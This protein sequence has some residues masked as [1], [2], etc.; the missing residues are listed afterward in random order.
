MFVGMGANSGGGYNL[1]SSLRFRSSASAYLTR[2][3]ASAG[4]RKTF[5][6]SMWA[7]RGKLGTAQYLFSAYNANN[8]N[9]LFQLL[10][11]SSDS[12]YWGVWTS[13][14]TS[15][16]KFRDP[17]A[18]YHIVVKIDTTLVGSSQ[19]RTYVNNVDVTEPSFAGITQNTDLAINNTITHYIGRNGASAADYQDGY[20]TEFNFIDGQALTPSDFGEYDITTGV[21][22]PKEY[23]GT[24]GTN[25]FYLPMKETQQATGFNTV[26]YNGNG[27][28]LKV[29]GVGFNPDLVWVKRRD[30]AVSYHRLI[31]S[32]RGGDKRLAS[33]DTGAETTASTLIQSFDADGYT[34]GTDTGMNASGDR[35]VAWC[36]D[37]GSSTV[38]NTDGTITS[39]VRANPATGFSVVTYVGN[40]TAGATVGHGL[41]TAP[42]MI[43]TKNRDTSTNWWVYHESIGNTKY[44]E[45]N[46]TITGTTNTGAWNNTSPDSNVFTLGSTSPSNANQVVAYCFSEVAGYSKFGSYTGNGSTSGPTVTT[47]FRPAFVMFKCTDVAGKYWN[48]Y[49]NTRDVANPIN[50]ALYPNTSLADTTAGDVD[51]TDTGFQLK[52]TGT[53]FNQSGA[54]YIYMAFADTRDAQFNFDASGNKN[55]WTANNINSNASSET[56]YDIMN[57]VATLTNEDTANFA[58]WNPLDFSGLSAGTIIYTNASFS[59]GNLKATCTTTNS[60]LTVFSTI[61]DSAIDKTYWE[62]TF[63]GQT[64]AYANYVYIG[65]G[66]AGGGAFYSSDGNYYNGSTWS[67]YGATYT[68]N[69]T[70]GIA[71]SLSGNTI[72]FFKNNVSQGVKTISKTGVRPQARIWNDTAPAHIEVNFGQRPFKYTPP[73]GYKKLN[74]YNLPDSTIV[75]GSQYMNPVLYTGNGG[76]NAI[77]TG[78]SPDLV[79]LKNRGSAQDNTLFDSIR[80]TEYYL[81]TNWSG[82][83]STDGNSNHIAY[84]SNGFTL[85]GTNARTNASSNSYVAWNWRGSDSSAVSNTDGTITSTVSANTTSG[86]SIVTYTG[87]GAVGTIGHGLQAA[88]SMIITKRRNAVDGWFT[89]H[90]SLGSDQ[91]MNLSTTAAVGTTLPDYWGTA[92]P[93]SSVYG[94]NTY[95]GNNT[96]GGTFVAYCFAEVEGFS[97]FGSYTGNGSADGPFVYTGFRPAFILGKNSN[98]TDGWFIYDTQRDTYNYVRNF[99]GPHNS[100]AETDYSGSSILFDIVSNGFKVRGSQP[101]IN[102]NGNTIIYMAFAEN[103]FKHSLAR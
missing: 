32:V 69:D 47:G 14:S 82:A 22:K 75:D 9:G 48:I 7:K 85:T 8:N 83:E 91:Y 27:T 4:N 39:S 101:T 57:D 84:D 63:S 90:S 26:I 59:D 34:V 1:E 73:T 79:W 92:D 2:T 38:S 99:L 11:S 25:G 41:G 97:K 17:S 94:V 65:D 54:N 45:L 18:W 36:W 68:A 76:T 100:N 3:P 78:F 49:D 62:A 33:N 70:I 52:T 56:T 20:I 29:T 77:T 31:D 93:T 103:P 6:I 66:G 89:Y 81:I 55:N 37:A 43:I 24:Y 74:T 30:N 42:K 58:T 71:T 19:V 50:T 23:T 51:F 86:F 87:T 98:T 102:N 15:P 28:E 61:K 80:G 67:A 5:T 72:E 12:L 13:G 10:W 53:G 88:P 16:A 21:W 40:T 95:G 35:Y 44:L 64:G 46:T 96:N 60:L